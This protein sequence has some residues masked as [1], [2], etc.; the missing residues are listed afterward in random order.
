MT[1]YQNGFVALNSAA[2]LLDQRDNQEMSLANLFRLI[3]LAAIWGASFAFM[4]VVAPVFGGIGTMWL[5]IGIAGFALF[6]YALITREQLALAHHWKHYLFIGL[7]SSALPFALFA[8]AMKTL[9]AGYGAILNATAP[10]FGALFAAWMIGERLTAMRIV[11]LVIGFFGVALIVNLGSVDLSPE[12]AIA[13]G[14]CI[15]ATACYGFISV[16]IKKYVKNAPNMGLAA[17]TL[18][19]ASVATA[20]IAIPLTNWAWPSLT[21]ALCLLALALLCSSV[22][23]VLYYRLIVDVGPTK[24]ISVTF[25]VPFFGVIWGGIFFGER[26]T[27]G[28][29]AGG[30]LVLY[31]MALVLGL[32]PSWAPKL[33]ES[34]R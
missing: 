13:V 22:A 18:M 31:G 11:G 17:G 23:Y 12:V 14:A 2:F 6:V 16:F 28:A 30:L 24:A 33:K 15:V 7:L 32:H 1:S 5:R 8:Y 20:P 19:L 27:L 26:L 21:V 29:I 3:S 10:F 4:R 9:P 34:S 25:L